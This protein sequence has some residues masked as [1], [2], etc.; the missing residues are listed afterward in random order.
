MRRPFCNHLIT[1]KYPAVN[2]SKTARMKRCT[3]FIRAVLLFFG[4]FCSKRGNS[5]DDA[6]EPFRPRRI[7]F[8]CLDF[9]CSFVLLLNEP[10]VGGAMLP[11]V[12][13]C[14]EIGEKVP[15]GKDDGVSRVCKKS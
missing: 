2:R 15:D 6:F 3:T 8:W 10:C 12:C 13:V 14:L 5:C 1:R 7:L 9:L 11:C 4:S